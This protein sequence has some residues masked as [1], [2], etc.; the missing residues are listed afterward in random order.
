MISFFDPIYRKGNYVP[1]VHGYYDRADMMQSTPEIVNHSH[2]LCEIMYVT[3]GMMSIETSD[4]VIRVGRKQFVWLDANVRHWDLRFS[5]GLCSMMNIEYQYELLDTRAPSLSALARYDAATANFLTHPLPHM[6][7]TDREDTVFHL[8]KEIVHLSDSTHKQS[9]HLCSLLCT[10]VM[11]EV[12][13]LSGQYHGQSMPVNNTY[14]SEALAIMQ[15]DY[16]E[17]LSVGDIASRLHIQPTYLH[18]LFKEHTTLTMGEHL[19]HIRIQHAQELL[20]TTNDTLLDIASAV[21]IGSQ[22]HFSQLF[23]RAVGVTPSEYRKQYK[24]ASASSETDAGLPY[25]S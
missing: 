2:S 10:Q 25:S 15:R 5:D 16:S 24:E 22:Q 12:A 14:V 11:L 9:E 6:V 23:R 18:R 1:V 4:G 20:L 8:I 17:P 13:R 21:G 7:L 3:E 19:Q